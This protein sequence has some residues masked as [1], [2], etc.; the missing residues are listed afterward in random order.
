MNQKLLLITAGALL[1]SGCSV[2]AQ[3]DQPEPSKEILDNSVVKEGYYLPENDDGSYILVSDGII[4]LCNYDFDTQ[5]RR[6]FPYDAD[7]YGTEEDYEK[8]IDSSIQ[9]NEEF[10]SQKE[11]IVIKWTGKPD[12]TM[13][14]L[15]YDVENKND[16]VNSEWGG[17]SGLE[18]VDESTISGNIGTYTY[19]GEEFPE[20]TSEITNQ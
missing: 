8:M 17:Y 5:L 14:V 6:D 3:A 12:I 18:L 16:I 13:L 20:E 1:L 7:Q 15:E 9:Y 19:Y 10:F 4:D 11:Y 2:A